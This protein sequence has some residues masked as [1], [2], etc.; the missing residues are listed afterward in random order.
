MHRRLAILASGHLWIDFCQGSIPALL[1]FFVSDLHISYAAAGGLIFAANISS[2]VLQPAFGHLADKRSVPWLMPVGLILASVCVSFSGFLTH[3]GTLFAVLVFAG[4]GSAAFHPE[5]VRLVSL[6]ARS[7][8]TAAM[9]IFAVGGN[10]GFALGPLAATALAVAFGLRGSAGLVFL[11]LIGVIALLIA[12]PDFSALSQAHVDHNAAHPATGKDQWAPFVRL[13]GP[14]MVRSILFFGLNT[15]LPLYWLRVL[16]ANK[17]GGGLALAVFLGAGAVG[18]LAGGWAAAYTGRRNLLLWSFGLSTPLLG[19]LL[20]AHQAWVAMLLLIP[21]GLVLFAPFSVIVVLGHEYLPRRLGT[22]SGVTFGLAVT[23]G[24]LFA[25]LLGRIADRYG[26][27]AMFLVLTVLPVFA[28][29]ASLS[30]PED[31]R[32]EEKLQPVKP[33]R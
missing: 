13:T 11:P 8:P 27:P 19:L 31:I 12:I 29:L 1:P 3:Y 28:W 21:V 22:A 6:S 15:F 14:I 4:M 7:S 18:T 25:P 23:V 32:P 2:S 17:A 26:L 20:L 5:A 9:S 24:G 16:G 30:L 10:L 33:A